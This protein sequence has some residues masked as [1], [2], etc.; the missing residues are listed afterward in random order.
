MLQ[1]NNNKKILDQFCQASGQVPNLSKSSTLF[2]KKVTPPMISLITS[3]FPVPTLNPNTIHLGHPLLFSH[4]DQNRAYAFIIN[5]FRAKL[6]TI[7]ANKLN[8]A[9]RLTYINSV[10][11]SIP[12]YYLYV[13]LF[14]KKN[15]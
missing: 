2:S 4:K 12:I 14:S 10:L 9:G 3:I 7:K 1:K 8:H 5:K 15:H 13:V 6:T 11:A